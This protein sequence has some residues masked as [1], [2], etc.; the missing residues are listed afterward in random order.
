MDQDLKE[1]LENTAAALK[2]GD[3]ESALAWSEQLVVEFPREPK[4]SLLRARALVAAKRTDEALHLLRQSWAMLRKNPEALRLRAVL[5]FTSGALDD[6]K[7]CARLLSEIAPTDRENLAFIVEWHLEAEDLDLALANARSLLK[8]HRDHPEAWKVFAE[9]LLAR[10][11]AEGALNALRQG[12]LTHPNNYALLKLARNIARAQD[13][14]REAL[15]Y[16]LQMLKLAPDIKNRLAVAQ[17]YVEL[18]E[19][20]AALVHAEALVELGHPHASILVAR[21]LLA[22][23]RVDEAI[24]TLDNSLA[25]APDDAQLLTAARNLAF[26]HGRFDKALSFGLCL[27]EAGATDRKSLDYVALSYMAAGDLD[28]AERYLASVQTN[29][30]APPDLKAARHLRRCRRLQGTVPALAEAWRSAVTNLLL[31]QGATTCPIPP[32]ATPPMIQYWS[33]GELPADVRLVFEEWEKLFHRESL[34]QVQLFDRSSAGEWIAE[35]TPEFR[36]LFA[37][38]FHYAMESDIFRIAYASKFPC[39]YVDI[40]GWPLENAARILRLGLQSR[41]SML[42]FRSYRPWILN[43]FFI[44][45]PECPFFRELVNQ[46]LSVDLSALPRN[47]DTIEATFGPTRYNKVLR[48]ILSETD[49]TSVSAVDGVPGC[50]QVLTGSEQIYFTHEAAVA[51]VKPPFPLNYK[52]T[53]DYW[54]RL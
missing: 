8:H 3:A 24:L 32:D 7:N 21:C 2:C 14:R 11:C 31:Q 1:L 29:A 28:S 17:S 13:Q 38:A 25:R 6:A 48:E 45:R 43:G 20:P 10:Q 4:T 50:A 46:T 34:G 37:G 54:K 52:A 5:A 42:Y 44:S 30:A 15:D 23:H 33:Q 41:R 49:K 22:Q 53:R 9:V 27:L 35:H 12:L 19:F 51:S 26:Q 16:S 40:D 36:S 47:H 39:I 18:G